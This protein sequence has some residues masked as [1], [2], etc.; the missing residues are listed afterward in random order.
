MKTLFNKLIKNGFL[1]FIYSIRINIVYKKLE[2]IISNPPKSKSFV[3]LPLQSSLL[4]ELT[5]IV[6]NINHML[7]Q[8]S[9]FIDQFTNLVNESNVNVITDSYGNMSVDVPA[10]MSEAKAENISKRLGVID[11]LINSHGSSLN[12]LFHKGLN[13]ENKLKLNDPNYSSQLGDKISEFR[14][15]NA[16]YKH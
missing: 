8:L 5:D 12:D 14:R 1:S 10:D 4:S 3:T 9:M 7:P 13:I 11:R 16:V 2:W 6:V 15:L